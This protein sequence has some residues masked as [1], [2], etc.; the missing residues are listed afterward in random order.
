[1]AYID[2]YN[3]LGVS[4][5]ASIDDIRKAYRKLARKY[6]PDVNPNDQEA[7]KKFQEINE[8][9]EVLSDPEKRKKYDEYGANWKNAEQFQQSRSQQRSSPEEWSSYGNFSDESGSFFENEAAGQ[10]SDFFEHLFGRG[11]GNAG[12]KR[13]RG[14]RGQDYNAEL[15]LSLRSAAQ[16]HKQTLNINGKNIRITVPAGVANGQTIK[17]AE[18]GAPGVS[19]GS[20]GDLYLTFV[21]ENDPDFQREDNDLYAV[22]AIDLYT[23]VLGGELTVNTLDGQV[24][25]KVKPETQNGT[26]VRLKGKG[27]PIY[28]KDGEYGDLFITLTVTIPVNLTDR[29]KQLFRELANS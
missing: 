20:A 11:S 19:G 7:H 15:H 14:F 21:I 2:Y 23:A 18:Q 5:N 8:A 4:R 9:N 29:Q 13:S 24:K 28:K 27:F 26:K 6:H 17:I 3:I 1:M 22:A 12:K 16:T 10:F 25:V